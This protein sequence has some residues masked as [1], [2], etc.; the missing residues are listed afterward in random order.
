MCDLL[1]HSKVID[2]FKLFISYK[3]EKADSA[4]S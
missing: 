3:E 4:A 1:K 2:F